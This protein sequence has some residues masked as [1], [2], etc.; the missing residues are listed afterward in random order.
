MK[1]VTRD[2][3]QRSKGQGLQPI[4]AEKE[5]VPHLPKGRPTNF[6][7]GTGMEYGDPHHHVW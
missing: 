1:W 2:P 4:Y 3:I 7:P 6:E 5:N